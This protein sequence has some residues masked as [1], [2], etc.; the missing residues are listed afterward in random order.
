VLASARLSCSSPTSGLCRI[1]RVALLRLTKGHREPAPPLGERLAQRFNEHQG[2]LRHH[3]RGALHQESPQRNHHVQFARTPP[4]AMVEAVKNA[5]HSARRTSNQPMHAEAS[6]SSARIAGRRDADALLGEVA[7]VY[8][9]SWR[10]WPHEHRRQ[11]LLPIKGD[12]GPKG[13]PS[14]AR[15]VLRLTQP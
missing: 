7:D 11:P 2:Q 14:Q 13:E 4:G 3:C 9:H 10:R 6:T 5:Q 15:R 8:R 1:E 12:K